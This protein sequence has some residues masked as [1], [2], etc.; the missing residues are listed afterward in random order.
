MSK[1]RKNEIAIALSL[2]FFAGC[3]SDAQS[4]ELSDLGRQV[5]QEK[6][7]S[8]P[9]EVSLTSPPRWEN[10]CLFIALDRTNRSPSTLFLTTMGPY[11]Y[12]ALDVSDGEA[13]KTESIEW[14]NIYGITDIIVRGASRLAPGTTIHN[15]F[16]FNPIV[17]VV[18]QKK[19]TRREIP[20]RGRLRVDVSYFRREESW[21]GN[22]EWYNTNTPPRLGPDGN[23]IGPPPA[24]APEWSRSFLAIPCAVADC[25][26]ECIRPPAGIPDEFRAIPDAYYIFPDWNERGKLLSEHVARR[27]PSCQEK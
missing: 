21:G 12:I 19:E 23:P 7:P 14:V 1:T 3:L 15:E 8:A 25:K 13:D 18:N 27:W 20:L 24:I 16:Y 22:K 5:R 2:F 11:F 9:L 4:Q 6:E 26:S 17:W 10:G